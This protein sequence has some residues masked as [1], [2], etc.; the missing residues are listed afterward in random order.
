MG[1]RL[2]LNTSS[3]VTIRSNT[4]STKLHSHWILHSYMFFNGRRPLWGLHP[5]ATALP[6][7]KISSL[8]AYE[9]VQLCSRQ[10][11]WYFSCRSIWSEVWYLTIRLFPGCRFVS[12]SLWE[13]TQPEGAVCCSMSLCASS[14]RSFFFFFL[15]LNL[16]AC[17]L[18]TCT[19]ICDQHTYVVHWLG[20]F[21]R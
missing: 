14:A 7:S 21:T 3:I 19:S 12:S 20:F 6:C 16:S 8:A 1:R 11:W 15:W 4:A 5:T 18:C 17:V 13:W 9:F 10:A 2:K